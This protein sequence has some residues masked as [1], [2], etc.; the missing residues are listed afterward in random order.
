MEIEQSYEYGEW[1][2]SLRSFLYKFLKKVY[3]DDKKAKAIIPLLSSECMFTWGKAFTSDSYDENYNYEVLEYYGDR[4]LKVSFLSYLHEKYPDFT[5]KQFTSLDIIYMSVEF[6]WDISQKL[7][8]NSYIRV[9]ENVQVSRKISTDVFEGFFGAA[10]Y[11][12]DNYIV[13]GFGLIF[14]TD[15]I[16][17]IFENIFK[18]DPERSLGP[19]KT[20]VLQIFEKFRDLDENLIEK[21][22]KQNN[23][24]VTSIYLTEEQ[25]K[26]LQYYNVNI[27]NRTLANKIHGSTKNSSSSSAFNTALSTLKNYGVT[28]DWIE[29]IDEMN[30]FKDVDYKLYQEA[31]NKSKD[32]IRLRFDLSLKN[33]NPNISILTLEGVVN[34]YGKRIKLVRRK[35]NKSEENILRIKNELLEEYLTQ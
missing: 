13:Q 7:G 31:I 10:K 6:Q 22:E 17:Y 30:S 12:G 18:I 27:R 9:S 32:Y 2:K 5:Q 1:H 19:A 15:I 16:Q 3:Q 28:T 4:T 23:G 29:S 33:A 34:T 26:I 14:C 8:F 35:F 25:L 24:F 20:Q 11:I 21:S